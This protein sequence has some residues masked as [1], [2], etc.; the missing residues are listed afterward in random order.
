MMR[1][2]AIPESRDRLQSAILMW[3]VGLILIL[4]SAEC[5]ALATHPRDT[6]LLCLKACI[7]CATFAGLV[8]VLRAATAAAALCGAMVCLLLT[9][10]TGHVAASPFAS[11]LSPLI[12]LFALTF[13]STRLGRAKKARA[14]LAESRNGRNAAQVLANLGAAALIPAAMFL[15]L[16]DRVAAGIFDAPVLILAALCEATADTVSSEIGQAFGGQPILITSLRRV[17]PGSDGAITLLG[18]LAGIAGAAI[19]AATGFSAMRITG[20]HAAIALAA[21]IIGLLFDS[22]LGATLERKGWLGNDLV[23]FSSTV[24][25]IAVAGM[26]LRLQR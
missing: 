21:G 10:G 9:V 4:P 15:G 23:N 7:I 16:F 18:T 12:V 14:G 26:A 17:T 20:A 6:G 8:L 19:V 3:A 25:A 24:F 11:A 2:K 13:L 5:V 1:T 22:L